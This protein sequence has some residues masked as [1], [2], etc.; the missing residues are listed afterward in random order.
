MTR[1]GA[2]TGRSISPRG[3]WYDFWTGERH[4]GPGGVSVAAPLDRLP[5][6]VRGGAILPPWAVG[7]ASFLVCPRGDHACHLSGGSTVPRSTRTT[8]RPTLIATAGCSWTTFS[9]EQLSGGLALRIAPTEGDPDVIAPGR[10][11]LVADS[12]VRDAKVGQDGG[13]HVGHVAARRVISDCP[14]RSRADRYQTRVVTRYG[15]DI[16]W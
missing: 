10:T 13:R 9:V 11:L 5:L 1:A 3:T 15:E 4:A 8:G 2:G 12:R 7:A 16:R 14:E 6:F